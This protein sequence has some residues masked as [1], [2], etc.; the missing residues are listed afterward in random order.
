MSPAPA[1]DR[2]LF[3]IAAALGLGLFAGAAAFLPNLGP[4]LRLF[5]IPSAS[6]SPTLDPGDRVLVS[7]FSYGLSR[8]SYDWFALPIEGRWP[9]WAPARGDVIALR[10]PGS[11][12]VVYVKR[13]VALSGE[14]VELEEGRLFI[15]STLVERE[16]R[17]LPIPPPTPN[18]KDARAYVEMLPGGVR[19]R[20]LETEGDDGML[21]STEPAIVPPGHVFVLGDNRD[22]SVDS[23]QS[24]DKGGPGMVPIDRFIGRAI[25]G[26]K[27]RAAD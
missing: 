17:P 22:N 8:W 15:D 11:D 16:E 14:T 23:R 6:M 1:S 25:L 12:D 9:A 13:V 21:D 20:I 7:R 4:N 24:S 3:A 27:L 18:G 10:P 5:A 26:G 19:H 2:R